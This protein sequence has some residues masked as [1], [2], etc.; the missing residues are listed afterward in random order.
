ML[1]SIIGEETFAPNQDNAAARPLAE[2]SKES[3]IYIAECG[4]RRVKELE[5]ESAVLVAVAE[6]AEEHANARCGGDWTLWFAR[7]KDDSLADVELLKVCLQL[8]NLASIR[9]GKAGQ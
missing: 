8:R 6:A 1:K 7:Y 3:L 4:Q 9:G 5:S 2:M